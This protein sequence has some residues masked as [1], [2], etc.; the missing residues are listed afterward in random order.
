MPR[1]LNIQ[2]KI[3]GANLSMLHA[4]IMAQWDVKILDLETGPELRP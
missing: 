1:I 2:K 3:C 4:F